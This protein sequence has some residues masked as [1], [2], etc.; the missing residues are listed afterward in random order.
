MEKKDRLGVSFKKYMNIVFPDYCTQKIFRL[1]FFFPF[2][3][4]V[5]VFPKFH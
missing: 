4:H 5:N 2:T 3:F 1:E